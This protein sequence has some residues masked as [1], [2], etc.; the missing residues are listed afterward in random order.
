MGLNIAGLFSSNKPT[1]LKPLKKPNS[2]SNGALAFQK[3]LA[4]SSAASALL[5][6]TP[7][8]RRPRPLRSSA[9]PSRGTPPS[10]HLPAPYLRRSLPF[11]T[12]ASPR[13]GKNP[14]H[15]SLPIGRSDPS[16][17]LGRLACRK[18]W[19]ASVPARSFSSQLVYYS[20]GVEVLQLFNLLG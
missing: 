5:P 19:V 17:S 8:P 4:R 9:S 1:Y 20:G 11:R 7:S 10:L 6:P 2:T 16:V 15:G 13:R 14:T 12:G 3:L 18:P